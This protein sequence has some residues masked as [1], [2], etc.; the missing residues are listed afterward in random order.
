[1][2][3]VISLDEA[4]TAPPDAG[5]V[6]DTYLRHQRDF[7]D[8]QRDKRLAETGSSNDFW[9]ASSLGSCYRQQ[10][11]TRLGR[12]SLR[13]IDAD[14]RR[15]FAWGDHVED[16]V[17]TMYQ[18]CGLVVDTQMRLQHGSLVAR[19]DLLL[20][21][22]AAEVADIPEEVREKWSPEWI[23]MLEGLR[24]ELRTHP[25]VGLVHDEIKSAKSTAMRYMY[26]AKFPGKSQ[27]AR[28][29]HLIQVG[30]S[31]LL[32]T[33]VPDAV[34]PDF[35]QVTYVGKDAVGVLRFRVGEEWAQEAASRW[36]Y[37][38]SAWNAK[39][40]PMD[41]ECDCASRFGGK[42]RTFCKFFDGSTCC[43]EAGLIAA[44]AEEPF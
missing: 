16:F 11:L 3:N 9:Y 7:R 21:Y 22:P 1:M 27:G 38:D 26:N 10:Y 34:V 29:E 18:R 23:A 31:M 39:A 35:H 15:T 8:A 25:F 44:A 32:E 20:R 42:G 12:P 37:L 40:D 2:S 4:R 17:R 30:A 41:V 14:T 5:F 24:A 6:L 28:I 33:L 19:G 13:P 43:G 36:A